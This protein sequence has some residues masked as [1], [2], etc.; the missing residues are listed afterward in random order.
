MVIKAGSEV[1]P[2]IS[3]RLKDIAIELDALLPPGLN[4]HVVW[5][6]IPVLLAPGVNPIRHRINFC[7]PVMNLDMKFKTG[8]MNHSSAAAE[9]GGDA[10]RQ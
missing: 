8:P 5:D 2:E 3:Q 7:K 9:N 1:P 6:E 4:V 10:E